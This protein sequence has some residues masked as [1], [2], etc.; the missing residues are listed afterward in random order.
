MT[1]LVCSL[2]V[3]VPGK[4]APQGSKRAVGRGRMIE[5]SKFVGPWRDRVAYLAMQQHP[6]PIERTVPVE[7]RLDFVMPRPS[8]APKR[9]TPPAIRMP[10]LDKLIRAV[11]DALTGIAWAD[12]AQVVGIRATKRLAELDEGPGCRIR[13]AAAAGDGAGMGPEIH[14]DGL[15]PVPASASNPGTGDDK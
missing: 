3:F 15:T 4:P 12:D 1:V 9:S 7:L 13:V 10:D 14:G 6:V 5:S 2:D 11:G 8:S